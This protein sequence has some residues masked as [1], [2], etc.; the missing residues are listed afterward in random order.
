[1]RGYIYRIDIGPKYY[2]G[3][4]KR[5][6]TRKAEHF[7]KLRKGIHDN[8]YMQNSFNKYRRCSFVEVCTVLD[9]EDLD[10]VEQ[11][12]ID[13]HIDERDCLNM[14]RVASSPPGMKGMNHSLETRLKMSKAKLGKTLSE[15]T[16]DKI[17]RFQK[18][19]VIP[20]T[21]RENMSGSLLGRSHSEEA[22]AKMSESSKGKVVSAEARARMSAVRTG[23]VMAEIT[24]RKISER[25]NGAKRPRA[26]DSCYGRL[27][28]SNEWI[29]FETRR[30]A[31]EHVS[32]NVSKIRNCI[33]GK[34]RSHCG[35]EFVRTIAEGEELE[36]IASPRDSS[37]DE[38]CYGRPA[39]SNEWIRFEN[40]QSAVEHVGGISQGI[41]HCLAGQQFSHRGWEFTRNPS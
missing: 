41:Y 36:I 17:S 15:E 38:P 20:K 39:G 18:G 32:G 9:I 31:K 16:R 11:L 1:M 7:R 2:Y 21:A 22:K 5:L 34:Q 12:F 10:E 30:A 24:K 4:T 37:I 29:R 28:G 3:Q 26:N 23:R 25:L 33:L 14:A 40:R 19:K 35:W 6:K 13:L 27:L 8:C